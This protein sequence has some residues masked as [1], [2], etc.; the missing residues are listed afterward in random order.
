M[1]KPSI[2]EALN[3]QVNAELFSSYLYLSMA[4]YFE[5]Q[6]LPGMAS[7]MRVQAQEELA[8]AV[9]FFDFITERDGRVLLTGIEDPKTEW[10]SPVDVFADI[11]GHEQKV[12]G[13]INGL[14]DLSLEEKDHA[15]NTFL[16][17]F[18]TEQVEEEATAK[19]ILDQLKLIADH[20]MA[21]FML[22]K[23]LGQ[24]TFVAPTD[25]TA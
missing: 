15:T 14:V 9:K 13:L 11:H 6:T 1:L 19:T 4:A 7:W 5:S 24:R 2:Q 16:Q 3:K 23:E 10:T 22:D 25:T 21:L 18:V 8:H 20:P 12:T 17:W